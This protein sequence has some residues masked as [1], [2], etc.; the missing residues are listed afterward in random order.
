MLKCL[1]YDYF[2][3]LSQLALIIDGS[4]RNSACARSVSPERRL[5]AGGMLKSVGEEAPVACLCLHTGELDLV[6]CVVAV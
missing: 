2:L 4:F 1:D 6:G 5:Q 3:P